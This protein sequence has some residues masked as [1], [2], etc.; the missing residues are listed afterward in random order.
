MNDH[1]S[2]NH[3]TVYLFIYWCVCMYIYIIFTGIYII[4]T[5]IYE[6]YIMLYIL[7]I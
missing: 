7:Y 4:Y 1:K 3:L 5:D 6:T 2:A